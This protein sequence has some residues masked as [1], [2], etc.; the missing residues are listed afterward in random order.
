LSPPEAIEGPTFQEPWEAEV[1]SI[2]VGLSERGVFSWPE[3]TDALAA[4]IAAPLTADLPYY[5]Q[6]LLT[7]EQLLKSRGLVGEAELEARREAWR[8]AALATP[9]GQPIVLAPSSRIDTRR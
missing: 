3:W 5:E 2:A 4:V 6:W 8:S 1:F 7:L 9:H